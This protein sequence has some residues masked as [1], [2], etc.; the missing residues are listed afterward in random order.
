MSTQDRIS[1]TI[2]GGVAQ[3]VGADVVLGR[4]GFA[5]DSAPEGALVAVPGATPV[6]SCNNNAT[7]NGSLFHSNTR[8]FS[9][10]A[11][12]NSFFDRFCRIVS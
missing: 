2:E 6:S 4:A 12:E 1:V 3:H 10:N 5:D 11:F 7:A 9:V 8:N